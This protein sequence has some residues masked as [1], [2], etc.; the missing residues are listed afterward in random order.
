MIDTTMDRFHRM[1][2]NFDFEDNDEID[3]D[4]LG[5]WDSVMEEGA[6]HPYSD[7]PEDG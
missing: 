1:D 2:P 3:P 5:Y 7:D 6:E 4:A